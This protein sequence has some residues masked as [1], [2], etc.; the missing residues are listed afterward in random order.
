MWIG[1]IYY[2][3]GLFILL[4]SI[5][6]IIKHNKYW[7]IHEWYTKFQEITKRKPN[8]NEFDSKIDFDLYRGFPV[9]FLV[10]F[11]WVIIGLLTNSWYIFSGV[12]IYSF[13]IGAISKIIGKWSMIS[14]ILRLH[15]LILRFITYLYLIINHFHLHYNA[16]DAIKNLI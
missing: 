16:F 7:K 15:L 13:L 5:T 9:L 11:L 8:D 10:E 4:I 3:I 12:L 1:H 2:A 14:K 6:A